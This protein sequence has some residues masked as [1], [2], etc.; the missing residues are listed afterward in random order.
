[1]VSKG[2]HVRMKKYVTCGH[3]EIKSNHI[4][5]VRFLEPKRCILTQPLFP[6]L[7]TWKNAV[8]SFE[9]LFFY[10]ESSKGP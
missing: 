10:S 4:L 5:S 9:I 7:V 6:T 2:N 3:L 1:M 8:A